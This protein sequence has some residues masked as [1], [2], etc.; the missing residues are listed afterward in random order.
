MLDE[1]WISNTYAYHWRDHR[2]TPPHRAHRH[3]VG[4]KAKKVF[5][6]FLLI[7]QRQSQLIELKNEWNVKSGTR[8][9]W[10]HKWSMTRDSRCKRMQAWRMPV[11]QIRKRACE[12]SPNDVQM[13]EFFYLVKLINWSVFD[14]ADGRWNFERGPSDGE[15]NWD[16]AIRNPIE[17]RF[18]FSFYFTIFFLRWNFA[19]FLLFKFYGNGEKNDWNLRV[20][21]LRESTSQTHRRFVP[22]FFFTFVR[23]K[24]PSFVKTTWTTFSFLPFNACAA[25]F[26]QRD[27]ARHATPTTETKK[28]VFND[29]KCVVL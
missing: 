7:Y 1:R 14:N 27:I 15:K 9:C 11:E 6:T 29:C 19:S 3:F 24:S 26:W 13:L 12:W 4:S 23:V 16:V 28:E 2:P 5:F 18:S 20:Y 17:R 25:F 21:A 22:P 8:F 10:Q